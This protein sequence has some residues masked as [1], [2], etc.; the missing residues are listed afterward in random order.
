M[1]AY[2]RRYWYLYERIKHEATW[3]APDGGHVEDFVQ[4]NLHCFIVTLCDGRCIYF[5]LWA[6]ISIVERTVSEHLD[7]VT[8]FWK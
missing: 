6:H 5:W 7:Y 2:E 8:L 4:Q 1:K 3:P